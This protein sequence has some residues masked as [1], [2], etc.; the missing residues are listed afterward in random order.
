MMTSMSGPCTSTTTTERPPDRIISR[1]RRR[2]SSRPGVTFLEVVLGVVLMGL[3]AA[4]LGATVS[5][6]GKSFQRQRDR[7]AAAELASRILLIRVDDEAGMPDQS[8]PVAYG[9]REFRWKI[10]TRP[11]LITLAGPAQVRR[12]QRAA[13]GG[14]DLSRR[15]LAVT[16]TTW[17][18]EASGG[19]YHFEPDLPHAVMTR[20]ID[21]IA[22]ST[23]DSAERRLD[24]QEG[25][26]RFLRDFV[27]TTT[28]G[29]APRTP[30]QN[31]PQTQPQNQPRAPGAQTPR[32]PGTGGGG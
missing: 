15:I 21:P 27:N 22:F 30:A 17:L 10:E 4:T 13:G 18:A 14:V 3:V 1:P 8:L 31:Q 32:N 23:Q 28:G 9:E 5:A 6:V 19:A 26:E 7:L 12:D 24:T 11:T 25:I 20:L 2:T 16:V 29:A